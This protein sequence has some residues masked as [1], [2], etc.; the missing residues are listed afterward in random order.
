M[1]GAGFPKQARL[2]SPGQFKPVF[3]DSRFRAS[4]REI[5]ILARPN[6]T[7]QPRLGL[8]VGKKNCKLAN[9][10]NRFKRLVRESFRQ[11]QEQLAG[12]DIIVLARRGIAEL[13]N[14]TITQQLTKLWNRI[15][16]S[17][18]RPQAPSCD[19]PPSL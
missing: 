2:L 3:D 17:H 12:L 1:A 4:N 10:R 8:V 16:S 19:G 13:D 11:Q 15:V 7:S 9:Q 6:D 18:H 14:R 5:L